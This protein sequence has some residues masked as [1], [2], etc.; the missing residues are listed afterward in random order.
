MPDPILT[1]NEVA[2]MLARADAATPAPWSGGDRLLQG[3]G[4]KD[5][6]MTDTKS[7]WL[8]PMC[9]EVVT[10]ATRAFEGASICADCWDVGD[11][12]ETSYDGDCV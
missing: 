4:G 9:G 6:G 10:D 5:H 12:G 3:C 2:A 11:I 7:A 8:C 1:P